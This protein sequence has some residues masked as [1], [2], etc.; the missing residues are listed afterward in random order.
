MKNIKKILAI[1]VVTILAFALMGGV[2][3]RASEVTGT[4]SSDANSSGSQVT[5]TVNS[6]NIN[7]GSTVSGTISGNG[8]G[9]SITG[10]VGG[11]SGGGGGGGSSISGTVSSGSGGGSTITGNVSTGSGGEIG[12]TVSQGGG[13]ILGAATVNQTQTPGL[14]NTGFGPQKSGSGAIELAMVMLAI[15]LLLWTVA[16]GSPQAKK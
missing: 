4:L 14:P 7:N 12:G 5:G 16:A 3:A 9:S 10:T 11:T 13:T 8:G 6:G 2:G 1:Q 15:I